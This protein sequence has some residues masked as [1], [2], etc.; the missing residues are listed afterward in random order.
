MTS[1]REVVASARDFVARGIR[2]LDAG[3]GVR[4]LNNESGH[5]ESVYVGEYL[6]NAPVDHG[7]LDALWY[8]TLEKEAAKKGAFYEPGEGDPNDIFIGRH[9][10]SARSCACAPKAKRKTRRK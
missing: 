10:T 8:D 3:Q 2:L 9:L 5:T 1:R 7:P 6:L 4:D